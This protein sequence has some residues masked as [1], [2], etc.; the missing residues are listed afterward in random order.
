MNKVIK[1]FNER[2]DLFGDTETRKREG[3]LFAGVVI[4]MTIGMAVAVAIMFTL[5]LVSKGIIF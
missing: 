3:E 5:H 4:G 2:N 1:W